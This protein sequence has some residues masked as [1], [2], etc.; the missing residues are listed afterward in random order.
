LLL[1]FGLSCL[2]GGIRWQIQEIRITSGNVSIGMLLL[3][4]MGIVLPAVL[5]LANE[6]V[7][8]SN[9][10]DDQITDSDISFSR[11][12]AL[13][14]IC[15]YCCY[16]IFQLGSHKDE[17]EYDGDEYAKFGG[18]HNIVRTP[19]FQHTKKKK[20]PVRRNEFCQRYCL[21][22][23]EAEFAFPTPNMFR[24]TEENQYSYELTPQ[25]PRIEEDRNKSFA[26]RRKAPQ[27]INMDI[28]TN[29]V[30]TTSQC[31]NLSDDSDDVKDSFLVKSKTSDVEEESFTTLEGT[32]VVMS[33]RMGLFWLFVVTTAISLIS[34]II[35]ETIDG[36]AERSTMSEVFTSVIIVP[37]FSN[38][39]EQVSAVIF[40]YRNKM[41]YVYFQKDFRK[42]FFVM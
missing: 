24:D 28:C 3:A 32:E 23:E 37:Y 33:M 29:E 15:G 31:D 10:D 14:M 13:V 39:A 26:K 7:S 40:A 35:V 9:T 19:H 1:V 42:T 25:R 21:L 38:I 11:F 5:K 17:F 20:H 8:N 12:N 27:S 2:I 34:C 22:P 18:G 41:E 6:S 16:L 30:K 4:T 36:F